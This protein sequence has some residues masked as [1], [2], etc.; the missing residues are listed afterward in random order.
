MTDATGL[1]RGT[2]RSELSAGSNEVSGPRPCAAH[3]AQEAA[4]QHLE[5][6]P[7]G[8][9]PRVS[10]LQAGVAAIDKKVRT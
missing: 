3:G 8:E 5:M 7:R 4:G 10:E 2:S 6:L 9:A 1:S